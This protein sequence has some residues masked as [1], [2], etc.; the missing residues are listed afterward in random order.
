MI[1][2]I[3]KIEKVRAVWFF[4]FTFLLT[5][6]NL[7]AQ[8]LKLQYDQPRRHYRWE[9]PG[10]VLWCMGYRTERRFS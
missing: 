8:E 4:L 3:F 10:L 7:S 5:G 1:K 6:I 2:T 9:I